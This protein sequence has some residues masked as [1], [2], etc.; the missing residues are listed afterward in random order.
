MHRNIEGFA[1][2][3]DVCLI[4]RN[5]LNF[6]FRKRKYNFKA[7]YWFQGTM[8]VLKDLI[9][10]RLSVIFYRIYEI[11][12]SQEISND[13][14]KLSYVSRLCGR[15]HYHRATLEKILGRHFQF[16]MWIPRRWLLNQGPSPVHRRP[17][18]QLPPIPYH[19]SMKPL[20]IRKPTE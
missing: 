9:I 16:Y 12:L 17:C 20:K 18:I 14:F 1:H 6:K 11:T 2:L 13:I 4:W 5:N 19:F 8:E 7:I 3:V 15:R 10:W